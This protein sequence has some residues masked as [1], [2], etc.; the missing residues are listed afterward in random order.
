MVC[1]N[2]IEKMRKKEKNRSSE[3]MVDGRH[4]I[5][6]MYA[7]LENYSIFIETFLAGCKRQTL[8]LQ[9]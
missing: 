6:I 1:V 9:L 3:N 8:I 4:I 2:E 5:I 7:Y